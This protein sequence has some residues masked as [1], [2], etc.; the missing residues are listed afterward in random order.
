MRARR[1]PL[2]LLALALGLA[3]CEPAARRPSGSSYP[4]PRRHPD[5]ALAVVTRPGGEGLQI[6]LDPDTTV[7]G[8]CAPRWNPD[9]ARLR[10]GDGPRPLA[11]GRAPRQEFYD[12]MERG[13]VRWRLRQ[14]YRSLCRRVAPDRS[15]LW[16]EPPRREAEYH[17]RPL[18]MLE[19]AHLLSDPRAI[20]RA[21][22]GLLGQPLSPDDLRSDDP[23]P[24]PPGP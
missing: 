14:L 2:L 6:W 19:E 18:L 7:S 4:L 17:P 11:G 20:R 23:P 22:K 13:L 15:F 8:R 24:E 21:E 10:G 16:L 1:L 9:A 3:G 5:D 12:A